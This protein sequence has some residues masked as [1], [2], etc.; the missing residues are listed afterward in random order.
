M[1]NNKF[2]AKYISDIPDEYLKKGEIYECWETEAP[3]IYGY[4]DKNGNK[5]QPVRDRIDHQMHTGQLMEPYI[6]ISKPDLRS[7]LPHSLHIDAPDQ[8]SPQGKSTDQPD[9][10]QQISFFLHLYIYEHIKCRLFLLSSLL[11]LLK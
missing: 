1:I 3:N 4:T 10:Y 11:L 7:I 2:K 9:T 8:N 5:P 6:K